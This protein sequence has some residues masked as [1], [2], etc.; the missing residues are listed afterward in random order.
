[1]HSAA[2]AGDS[3]ATAVSLLPCTKATI[4]VLHSRLWSLVACDGGVWC[5]Q[6]KGQ[7]RGKGAMQERRLD[8]VRST[9]RAI[10]KNKAAQV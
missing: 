10:A 3:N 8:S 2:V 6:V 5:R 9:G 7:Q 1:M 4:H